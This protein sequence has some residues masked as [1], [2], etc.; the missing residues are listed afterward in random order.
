M[1]SLASNNDEPTSGSYTEL[2]VTPFSLVQWTGRDDK[3][4]GKYTTIDS[5]WVRGFEF[6]KFNPDGRLL[7][8]DHDVVVEWRIGKQDKKFGWALH[9]ANLIRVS[10][11]LL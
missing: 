4:R 1:N 7:E 9:P 8:T 2:G 6:L 11:R 3:D 10:S 5:S